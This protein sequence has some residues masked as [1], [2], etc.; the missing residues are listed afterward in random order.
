MKMYTN[1]ENDSLS[2]STLGAMRQRDFVRLAKP[3]GLLMTG[4]GT[5]WQCYHRSNEV[6]RQ[7]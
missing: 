1:G 3:G 5:R 2:A 4:R 7:T 6:C